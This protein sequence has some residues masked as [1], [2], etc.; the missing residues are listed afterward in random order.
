MKATLSL[1]ILSAS[2]LCFLNYSIGYFS[3]PYL[4]TPSSWWSTN[5]SH[6]QTNAYFFWHNRFALKLNTIFCLVSLLAIVP[7]IVLGHRLQQLPIQL[8]ALFTLLSVLGV[9]FLAL[10]GMLSY[11]MLKGLT[12]RHIAPLYL[13][14]ISVVLFFISGPALLVW[15][16]LLVLEQPEKTK[17]TH[18]LHLVLPALVLA[19]IYPPPSF[20]DYPEGA[21][22]VV[23]DGIPGLL[24]PYW[25]FLSPNLQII[26]RVEEKRIWLI[27]SYILLLGFSVLSIRKKKFEVLIPAIILGLDILTPEEIAHISPLAVVRRVVPYAFFLPLPSLMITYLISRLA[28]SQAKESS[29][30][31]AILTLS[32]LLLICDKFSPPKNLGELTA[33]PSLHTELFER[34][35]LTSTESIR[36]H[37][38]IPAEQYR[39]TTN[40]K[41]DI[42][43]LTDRRKATKIFSSTQQG[44]EFIKVTFPTKHSVAGVILSSGH[45]HTDF[46]RAIS[47]EDCD[48]QQTIVPPILWLGSL[49]KTK[50]GHLYHEAQT[51]K[52]QRLLFEKSVKTSCLLIRQTGKESYFDWSVAELRIFGKA[53]E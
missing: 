10:Y 52:E 41:G 23:D 38:L 35:G 45:F 5:V 33:S 26:N 49:E 24:R 6:I 13:P 39:V 32:S 8:L 22:L 15:I 19:L 16:I 28:F 40:L 48:N 46:P 43:S 2:I 37:P 18:L 1:I 4:V 36:K 47:V 17:N 44:I 25:G 7:Q 27:P 21:M 30:V 42:K 29:Q 12:R 20:P 53:I 51:G 14:A 34:T 9:D 50:K 11:L 31:V 3:T